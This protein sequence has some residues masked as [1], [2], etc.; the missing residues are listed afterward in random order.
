MVPS[1]PIAGEESIDWIAPVVNFHFRVP[2]GFTAYRCR[3]LL[4]PK[5][6]VPSALIAGEEKTGLPAA[7]FHLRVPSGFTA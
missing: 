7:N 6:M 1:A 5:K 2:S 3:S 4:E